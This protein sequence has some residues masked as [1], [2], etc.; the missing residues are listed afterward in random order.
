MGRPL[1]GYPIQLT[2]NRRRPT[3]EGKVMQ[4]LGATLALMHGY[5]GD[6]GGAMADG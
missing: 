1:P 5:Q 4:A 3:K 2:D 6:E